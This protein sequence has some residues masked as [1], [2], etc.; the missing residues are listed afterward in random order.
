MRAQ[1]KKAGEIMPR[2]ITLPTQLLCA[3]KIIFSMP[4]TRLIITFFCNQR[5]YL[6]KQR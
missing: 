3:G 2:Q 5:L 4:V 6:M 1:D